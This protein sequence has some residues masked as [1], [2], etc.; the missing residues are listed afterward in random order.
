MIIKNKHII[1]YICILAVITSMSCD[2]SSI[3]LPGNYTD[4]EPANPS[5]YMNWVIFDENDVGQLPENLQGTNTI[6][7]I[8]VVEDDNPD[9]EIETVT[10]QSQKVNGNDRNF[11]TVLQDS[12]GVWKVVLQ[13]SANIDYETVHSQN[14]SS[15][16]TELVMEITDDSPSKSKGLLTA[17]VLITNVNESPTWVNTYITTDLDEGIHY[18]SSEI[19]WDDVDHGGSHTLS[20]DDLPGWL[21]IDVNKLTGTP[22]T[23]DVNPSTS[24]T[25]KLQDQGGLEIT[26]SFTINVRGNGAPTFTGSSD[27]TW[28]EERSSS[29]TISWSDP[30]SVDYST[31]EASASNLD[32][33]LTFTPNSSGTNGT[34]SGYLPTSYVNQTL[35]FS[36]TLNDNRAGNPLTATE[37]FT[38]TVDPND[39]PNFSNTTSIPQSLNHG[40][41]YSF[42]VNWSDPDGDNVVL[43]WEN[44]VTWLNINSNGQL[45]GTPSVGDINSSGTVLLTITDNR[46]NVPLSTDYSFSITVGENFAPAFTNSESVDTTATVGDEYSFEFAISDENSD[47]LTFTVPTKPSWLTYNASLYK[48]Y[49]TPPDSTHI[50]ANGV[51]VKA[52]DCGTST[53]FDFSIEVS[54]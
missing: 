28:E 30:N 47:A 26:K 7:G 21:T 38:I 8:I 43:S 49:G 39:A 22:S 13:S 46:P 9:D 25:L 35:T 40:C 32:S 45:S 29:W 51:T 34:V 18:E 3:A 23:A 24:F 44:D 14:G 52:E 1:D 41:P 6:L 19:T 37:S 31:M 53:S 54:E 12:V 42:D 4:N 11:F 33:E 17:N 16:L 5:G 20:S 15:T 50:G 2:D 27:K 48:I 36:V 10:I